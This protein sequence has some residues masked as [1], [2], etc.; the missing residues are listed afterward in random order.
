MPEA[1]YNVSSVGKAPSEERSQRLKKY[2]L[3]M[4]VRMACIAAMPFAQGWWILIFALGAI[5]LPYVAVVLANVRERSDEYDAPESAHLAI[6]GRPQTVPNSDTRP[7]PNLVFD[8]GD[9]I[10]IKHSESND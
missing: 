5:F 3:T 7:Q 4:S 10:R 1:S 6:T 8:A 9:A 2:V